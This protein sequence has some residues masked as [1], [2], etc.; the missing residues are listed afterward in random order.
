MTRICQAGRYIVNNK[1]NMGTL[2]SRCIGALNSNGEYIIGL[3]NDDIFL[4]QDILET[5]Y[6]NAKIND[7]DIVEIKSLNIP[8]YSPVYKQIKNGN[9]IYHS[10]NLILHQPELASFSISQKNK[11][12][13]K[14]HFIWGKL[15]KTK[16]YKKAVNKLGYKRYSINNCWTEDMSVVFLLFNEAKSYIFLNLFGIFR[17]ISTSTTTHKLTINQKFISRVYFLGILFDFSKNDMKT[18]NLIA[19][20]ALK[21]SLKIVDKLGKKNKDYFLSIIKKLIESKFVSQKYKYKLIK[22]FH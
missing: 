22:N 20:Y 19:T 15:I 2:Y 13:F 18:K 5:I 7:F 10:N 11:L 14:D 17:L 4:S 21:F 9:Y 12:K 1:K 3:D 16:I 6:F 8:N